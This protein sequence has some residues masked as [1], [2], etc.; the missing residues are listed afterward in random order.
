MKRESEQHEY[1]RPIVNRKPRIHLQKYT[2]SFT[3]WATFTNTDKF[4]FTHTNSN[5]E[6]Q[7]QST[8]KWI[9][10]AHSIRYKKD[11]EANRKQ[12]VSGNEQHICTNLLND[13]H[14]ILCYMQLRD[15]THT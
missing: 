6:P 10:E 9:M 4:T 14:N 8:N 13:N 2:H 1:E 12:I 11:R 15:K 5:I 3:Q 7:E